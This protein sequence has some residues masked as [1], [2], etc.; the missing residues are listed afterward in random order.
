MHELVIH[1]N[2]EKLIGRCYCGQWELFQNRILPIIGDNW[3]ILYTGNPRYL[4]KQII[5]RFQDHAE[6]HSP[7]QT[8][9]SK[10]R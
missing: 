2:I 7:L 3:I 1:E 5:H 10:I 4:R 8:V 9:T 6:R